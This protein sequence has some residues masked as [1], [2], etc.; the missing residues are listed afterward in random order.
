M[1]A[2]DHGGRFHV[3]LGRH[4]VIEF[5]PKSDSQVQRLLGSREDVFADYS[6]AVFVREFGR[7]FEM[8]SAEPIQGSDRV[9][10]HML[11]RS[12]PQDGDD[13]RFWNMG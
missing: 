6:E 2:I 4:L 5:V 13:L 12:S 7:Y 11:T 10:Y 3:R 9:L 1:S 8:I